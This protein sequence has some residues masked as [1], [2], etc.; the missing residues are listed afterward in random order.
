[1]HNEF[2]VFEGYF[3]TDM[4]E[5]D[6]RTIIIDV[7]NTQ[8]KTHTYIKYGTFANP[9]NKDYDT[10]DGI[11]RIEPG[12]SRF[13]RKGTYYITTHP[14]FGFMDLLRDNYY[15]FRMSWRLENNIMVINTHDKFTL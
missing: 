13:N 12:D 7:T 14:Y 4:T 2:D 9:T 11:I 3:E 15:T 8:G 6:E 5:D 1:L 10:I